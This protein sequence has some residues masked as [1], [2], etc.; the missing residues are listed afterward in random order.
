MKVS[1]L[2]LI[3][4]NPQYV[5]EIASYYVRKINALQKSHEIKNFDL[6]DDCKIR[7]KTDFA[8][9]FLDKGVSTATNLI[10]VL[11][12]NLDYIKFDDDGESEE[13]RDFLCLAF[14]NYLKDLGED[15]I[16]VIKQLGFGISYLKGLDQEIAKAKTYLSSFCGAPKE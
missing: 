11:N 15:R 4:N 14:Q 2:A 1:R 8:V 13:L 12:Q 10:K 3:V 5:W 9:S 6:Q 7:I 16:T